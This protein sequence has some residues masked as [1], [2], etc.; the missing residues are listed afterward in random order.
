MIRA[1][2]LEE[3]QKVTGGVLN[4]ASGTVFN[5]VS[6]DS[7]T[8]Q[9][10]D[11]FIAISGPN[12][13]GN[14]FVNNAAQGKAAAAIISEEMNIS[15]PVLKV[16][17]TRI[18]LGQIGAM[19]RENSTACVIALTGSQGKTTVKEMVAEIL[20]QCGDVHY[21]R[22]NLNNDFGVPLSLLEINAQHDFSVIEIGASGPGEVAYCVALAKPQVAHITNVA[23]TH[24]EGFGDIE[25]IA[26]A[27]GELWDG[28]KEGGVAVINI[29]DTFAKQWC[30]RAEGKS[31]ITI[32]AKG[33]V[34]ADYYIKKVALN[35]DLSADFILHTPAGKEAIHVALAGKHN[36]AN[37]LA[38]AALSM[39][40]GA[41]LNDVKNALMRVKPVPGRL[42]KRAGLNSSTI[43]DDTYNASP[44]SFRAAIDV[45][46][47]LPGRKMIAIGDMGELG[48]DAEAAH[49]ELGTYAREKGLDEFYA[50]GKLSRLA[51]SSFGEKAV[52]RS[53]RNALAQQIIPCLNK[54]V[55]LLVKGSRSA[56]MEKLV[57]LLLEKEIS[58]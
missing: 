57:Q 5:S 14:N 42:C 9:P 19:N 17:D 55:V 16:N 15:L 41:K 53:E 49:S 27:K 43:I 50:T 29:D 33:N 8:L 10:E 31:L 36:T 2:S 34:N 51:A 24:L 38:A 32:S 47:T 46:C 21:T 6:I 1:M 11:L 12:F 48:A 54:G 37:A 35:T 56:G 13:N 25:G 26:R 30:Q 40:A 44:A 22:G 20:S 52:Y 4:G 45:L 3:V 7:R 28:I 39:E 23:D 18:A 58:P